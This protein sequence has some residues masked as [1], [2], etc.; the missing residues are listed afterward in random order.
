MKNNPIESI[1]CVDFFKKNI[2]IFDHFCS[3]KKLQSMIEESEIKELGTRFLKFG[4][5]TVKI[6]C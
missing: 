1:N 2:K 5:Y 3:K 4:K 6:F